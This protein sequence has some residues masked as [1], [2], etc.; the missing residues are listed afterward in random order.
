MLPRDAL[1]AFLAERGIQTGVYYP[2]PLS[3]QPVFAGLGHHAGDFPEAEAAARE[4][5]SLPVHHALRP[6]DVER[7]VEAIVDFRGH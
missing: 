2:I 6:G 1:K 3:L 7:V 5:L 4:V